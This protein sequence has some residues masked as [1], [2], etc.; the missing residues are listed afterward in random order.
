MSSE[1]TLVCPAP[2]TAGVVIGF[3][4]DAGSPGVGHDVIAP[5]MKHMVKVG[6]VAD[7]YAAIRTATSVAAQINKVDNKLGTLAAGKLADVI[8]VDGNPV[9]NLDAISNVKMTFVGGRRLV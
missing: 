2:A 9:E 3:G 6:V 4:K 1:S 7:N 5:E 8:V